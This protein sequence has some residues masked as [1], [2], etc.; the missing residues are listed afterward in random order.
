MTR[1]L[2]FHKHGLIS[3]LNNLSP[4]PL[5]RALLGI[6]EDGVPLLL[7]LTNPRFGSVLIIGDTNSGKTNLLR[8][9]IGSA[10]YINGVD[11]LCY[12]VITNRPKEWKTNHT[13]NKPFLSITD[14]ETD[15][16]AHV[17]SNLVLE[18]KQRLDNAQEGTITLLILDDLAQVKKLGNKIQDALAWLIY[19]GPKAGIWP[20]ASLNAHEA[21][22][23]NDWLDL[24]GTRL[25]GKI[26]SPIIASELAVFPDPEVEDLVTGIEFSVWEEKKWN[27]F[28][29][30][31]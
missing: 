7:D 2:P 3:M 18:V 29:I 24:F 20:I 16:T 22:Q 12:E 10:I 9:I 1:I 23:V 6:Q 19:Y 21:F 15:T 11:Q 17:L 13:I 28:K 8:V 30:P 5:H 27:K 31:V 14:W 26:T 25:I 4:L